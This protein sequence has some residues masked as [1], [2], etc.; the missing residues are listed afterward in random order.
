MLGLKGNGSYGGLRHGLTPLV[1]P[2]VLPPR[3]L[4]NNPS[5]FSI[6]VLNHAEVVGKAIHKKELEEESEGI[7]R[8]LIRIF[9]KAIE[10]SY[11]RAGGMHSDEIRCYRRCYRLLCQIGN[12]LPF[13][14][15]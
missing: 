15:A 13:R 3:K 6:L 5:V 1:L 7:D 12:T 2:S 4:L 10:P 9:D 14:L 11:L 8:S